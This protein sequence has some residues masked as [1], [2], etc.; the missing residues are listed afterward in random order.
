MK[1][2]TCV[3]VPDLGWIDKM[4]MTSRQI[5]L[6]QQTF[7][8]IVPAVESVDFMF[9]N[10][11]F[12][13]D[14]AIR[15]LFV[16]DLKGQAKKFTATLAL[17]VNALDCLEHVLTAVQHL[18]KRHIGYGVHPEDYELVGQALLWTLAQ[19]LGDAF[20]VEVEEAWTTAYN[21]IANIML[22][23]AAET[24]SRGGLSH[25]SKADLIREY[26]K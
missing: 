9:F 26:R 25:Q 21:L 5:Q 11:L 3:R 15:P 7:R 14:P 20:T 13:L 24:A 23:A 2:L 1:C 19:K 16:N 17:I 6:V 18:G 10:R 22:E 8:L 4:G 12:S